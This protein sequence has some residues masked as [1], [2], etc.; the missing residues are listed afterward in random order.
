MN[1]ILE[2]KTVSSQKDLILKHLQ[3]IGSITPLE[4]L[5]KYGCFRLGA[6]ILELRREG[7]SIE[8]VMIGEDGKRYAKY[9]FQRGSV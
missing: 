9:V 5:R 3:E 6:R 8:T 7:F 1:E 4:C 2:P